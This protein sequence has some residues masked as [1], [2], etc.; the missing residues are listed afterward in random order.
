MLGYDIDSTLLLIQDP[1][2]TRIPAIMVDF[3]LSVEADCAWIRDM[4]GLIT[5][6]GHV[7]DTSVRSFSAS[8]HSILIDMNRIL[9]QYP[10]SSLKRTI[11]RK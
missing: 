8:L 6:V 2:Y 9:C 5:V 7:E 10:I 4:K 3:S 11:H 1:L